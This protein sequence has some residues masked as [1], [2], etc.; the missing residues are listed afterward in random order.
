MED[1]SLALGEIA[2][3][4]LHRL[5]RERLSRK[6]GAHL[7]E[8]TID[9]IALSLALPLRGDPAPGETFARTVADEIDRLLDEAIQHAASFHPG[10]AFCHRCGSTPCE[11]SAAP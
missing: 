8:G 6:A 5:V 7:I 3:D 2:W 10:H 1:H 9:R 4:V 11:H